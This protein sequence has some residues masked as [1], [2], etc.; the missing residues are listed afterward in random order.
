MNHSNSKK[1]FKD[2]TDR[3]KLLVQKR[4]AYSLVVKCF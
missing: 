4:S 1:A 2:F 3:L